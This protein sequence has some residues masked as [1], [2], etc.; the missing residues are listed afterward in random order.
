MATTVE[1]V[2]FEHNGF[3]CTITER[4]DLCYLYMVH[5]YRQSDD[6]D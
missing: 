6:K 3:K 2:G 1:M 5:G 4:P